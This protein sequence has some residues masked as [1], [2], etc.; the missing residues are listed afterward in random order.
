MKNKE[1]HIILI[2]EKAVVKEIGRVVKK[3]MRDCHRFKVPIAR[4][5]ILDQRI[6]K[7]WG[8]YGLTGKTD[9]GAYLIAFSSVL[10]VHFNHEVEEA[11]RNIAAHELCHTCPKSMNHGKQWKRWVGVL[12]EHGYKVNPKPYSKK[13][14]PGLY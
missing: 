12:N 1:P 13:D 10:F 2:Y 14:T 5:I 9:K 6:H 11:V 8:W 3:V 4:K 7:A